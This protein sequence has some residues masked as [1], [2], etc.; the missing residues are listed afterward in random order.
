MDCGVVEEEIDIN[1]EHLT[2][3]LVCGGKKCETE[4]E[5]GVKCRRRESKDKHGV[6]RQWCVCSDHDAKSNEEPEPEECHIVLVTTPPKE[7]GERRT[8]RIECAGACKDKTMECPSQPE[9]LK[10]KEGES[11]K[12]ITW[13]CRCKKKPKGDGKDKSAEKK[14]PKKPLKKKPAKTRAGRR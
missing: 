9:N 14:A 10:E 5:T 7:K 12:T 13:A 1:G 3:S 6:R 4:G 11:G 2:Y 8:Q